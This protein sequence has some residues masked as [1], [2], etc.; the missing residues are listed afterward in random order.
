MFCL[1]IM[2]VKICRTYISVKYDPVMQF[3]IVKL[4]VCNNI[5]DVLSQKSHLGWVGR[6]YNCTCSSNCSHLFST[7]LIQLSVVKYVRWLYHFNA[8]IYIQLMCSGSFPVPVKREYKKCDVLHYVI[9]CYCL[10]V[11][12]CLLL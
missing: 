3:S 9:V 10:T 7:A 1:V 6:T 5:Y 4:R 11:P 8:L 12:I 2:H